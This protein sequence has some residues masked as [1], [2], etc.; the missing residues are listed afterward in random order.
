[1]KRRPILLPSRKG[2]QSCVRT[3]SESPKD[4]IPQSRGREGKSVRGDV[5]RDEGENEPC[6]IMKDEMEEVEEG[7]EEDISE[8]VG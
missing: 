6:D 1:M 8:S 3:P 5:W 2:E 7:E 4:E